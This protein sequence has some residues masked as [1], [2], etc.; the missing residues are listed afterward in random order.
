MIKLIESVKNDHEHGSKDVARQFLIS[1]QN[2]CI[3]KDIQKSQILDILHQISIVR[4]TMVIIQNIAHRLELFLSEDGDNVS[5][6]ITMGI[7]TLLKE[8]DK[9]DDRICQNAELYFQKHNIHSILTHSRSSAVEYTLSRLGKS[10]VLSSLICTESRPLNEGVT[11]ANALCKDIKTTVIADALADGVM[12]E[13][14]CVILGADAVDKSG[15]ILNKIGSRL[16]ALSAKDHGISVICLA[17]SMKIHPQLNV[18]ELSGG[19]H[20]GSEL[21][22]VLNKNVSIRNQYFEIVESGLITKIISD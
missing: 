14:N 16:I 9:S 22:H 7:E 20:S 6:E 3:D 18:E 11:M 8:M 12:D 1:L 15:N 21:G 19:F 17:G 10:G 4:P 2:L 5:R 13:C